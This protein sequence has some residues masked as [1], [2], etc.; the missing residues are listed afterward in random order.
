MRAGRGGE[1]LVAAWSL[2]EGR[3]R[4]VADRGPHGLDGRCVNG[5]LRAVTGR[6]WSGDVHDWR[7]AADQY[8]AMHF[9]SDA[10]DDLGWEPT[11]ELELAGRA[12]RAAS[13][14]WSS[15]PAG[16]RTWSRSS[17]A[18]R[19][20]RAGRERGPAADLHLPRLLVRARRAR[21]G[22]APASPRTAGSR[23]TG[24]RSLYDRHDDGCRR[25]RGLAAAAA[26]PAAPRLPLSPA[27]RAPRARP[28]PD[29]ARLPRAPRARRRPAHRPRP[30]RRGR[31]GAGRAPHGDH[32]RPPRVRDRRA[33]RRA[34]GARRGGGALAYLGG[35]GLNGRVSVDPERPHV[36][37]LRRNETQGL[38]WQA[39]PGEH[40]HAATGAYGG[41]WRRQ[42]RPEHRFLGVGLSAF[43][44]APAA[45][46]ERVASDADPAA[47]IV[48][49][50]IEPG[51]RD[52]P[53]R[54]RSSAAPPASRSTTTTRVLGSPADAVRARLGDRRARILD[55]ARRRPRRAGRARRSAAPTWSSGG[56]AAAAPC[57][58]SARSPGPAASSDDDANPVARVTENVLARARAR[59]PVRGR[60][61]AEAPAPATRSFD[62]VDRRRRPQRARRRRLPRPRRAAH[63]GLRAPPDRRRRLHHRGVRAR[64]PRLAGRLRAQ[65][66]A[67]GD[68]ARLLAAR[69]RARGA[70]GGAD[71][72]RLSRRRPA[73][74]ARRPRRHR[75]RARPL[76]PRRRRAPSPLFSERDARASPAL[77]GP[78]FDRA[79]A[80]RAGWLG[81]GAA[82]DARPRPPRRRGATASPPRSCSRPRP[83]STSS[84]ASAPS[85]S[86]PRSAGTRSRTRS[87]GPATPGTAYAL[88]HEHA[89][90]ALGGQTWGFVRG[91]MGEV[92]RAARGRRPRGGRRDPHRRRG[93]ARSR[94]RR[95][96]AVAVRLAS[97]EAIGARTVLSNADPKRTL[98]GLVDPGALDREVLRGDPRL[99]QRRRQHEDQPRGRRAAADRR[100]AA[101]PAAPPP[102]PGPA[103]AAARGDGPRPGGARDGR[104]GR[105]ARTSSSACR[106]RSTPRWPRRAATWS[107]SA[108]ARSPTGSPDSRPGTSERER[109][110]DRIIDGA[111]DDDPEPPGLGDRPP[112]ADARSTSSARWR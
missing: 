106:A 71:A 45:S 104:R 13:T 51:A 87:P 10:V 11:L 78:W 56:R 7:F 98:L 21:G 75:A 74:P 49:A 3:E 16:T 9:H 2:G 36:L 86:A 15:R 102:R 107:P 28:G 81:A 77:L 24:L 23:A 55:L 59:A 27:R 58:R 18:G 47:E 67:A 6:R 22:S 99:P 52:R 76:R 57:S 91:G 43:G 65:P 26:D 97:G 96:R 85:T 50:G 110:A 40:H 80:G 92:T 30:A 79:A 42:G 34:R 63:R 89:A 90:S 95:G 62:V 46:Y 32:R 48:F 111:R 101:R 69:P 53:P 100:H 84:S 88:L 66:P 93:R 103:D 39:L 31:R 20:R 4:R 94:S 33:A 108:S 61:M 19:R 82:A 60:A 35:N 29:P 5:P 109:V 14:P 83:A 1:R 25:L 8:E 41:D 12:A 38:A 68:L 73:H 72:E 17:S 37:E 70:R 64:L 112:G 44:E 105:G 54:A